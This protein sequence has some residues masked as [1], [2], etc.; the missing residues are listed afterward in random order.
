MNSSLVQEIMRWDIAVLHESH[1]YQEIVREV[2]IHGRWEE[3][4]SGIEL[5]L[6]IKFGNTGLE[7]MPVI[8]K[9]SD[10]QQ[11]KAFQHAIRTANSVEELR[12]L[13]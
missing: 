5:A 9:I 1:W 10:L 6:E 2:E 8:H 7:L 13:L 4:Y 3:L 11:L 12:K